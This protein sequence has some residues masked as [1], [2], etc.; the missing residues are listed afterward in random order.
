MKALLANIFGH[1][2]SPPWM[3]WCKAHPGKSIG[4]LLALLLVSAGLWTAWDWYQHLP[5]PQTVQSSIFAP[6][7]TNYEADK[8]EV[9]P[10][11]IRFS[12]SVAPLDNIGKPLNKGIKLSPEIAGQ[13]RWSSD[14]HLE[15][16]PD[17]DWPVDKSYSLTLD[18]ETLLASHILLDN[19]IFEFKTAP[20]SAQISD[21]RLYYEPN[22][23]N[24]QKV[25]ATVHFSHPVATQ[26]VKSALS[27]ML[28]PGLTY[29]QG[30]DYQLTFDD[31][32]LNAYIHTAPLATPLEPSTVK[33]ELSNRIKAAF[34]GNAAEEDSAEVSVPGRYQ[35]S[36]SAAQISFAKNDQEEPEPVLTMESSR[37]VADEALKGKVEAWLLPPKDPQGNTYWDTQNITDSVLR[38]AS[39][40]TLIQNPGPEGLNQLHSFKFQ[41]PV[42]RYLAVRVAKHV[43]GQGGY[44]SR[45]AA[46]SV[47]R[48]P[49]YPKALAFLGEGALLTLND[50]QRLGYL[51]RGVADVRI[52][53]AQLLPD[54]IH[55]L[56][57][58]DS[59][60]FKV[61]YFNNNLFDR[62]VTRT[63][64]IQKFVTNDPAKTSYGEV[65][66]KSYFADKRGIFVLK[67]TSAEDHNDRTFDSYPPE[68]HDLRFVVVT[69]MGILAKRSV[70]GS[71][72]IFVQS[73]S[74]GLP[75]ANAKVDVVGRNGLSVAEGFTDLDGH[76]H[77]P[78]LGQ[79]R[80]EKRPLFYRVE[81][82][83]DVSFLPIGDWRRELDMSR[84]D[85][86]GSNESED[87]NTLS[88]YLFTD[89]GLYRPGET[90]HVAS[91]VRSQ[92]WGASL[93]GLPVKMVVTDP[94]GIDV[95]DRTFNLDS[96]GFNS[97]D[98]S[99][100]ETAVAGEY[101]ASLSLIRDK[102]NLTR[103]GEVSFKV[104]D[105]E[106]DRI[107]VRVTLGATESGTSIGWLKPEE[108]S[109]K[110]QAEQ[111]FGG[112]AGDRRVTGEMVLSPT[113]I[114]FKE[115]PGYYFGVLGELKESFRETLAEAKTN[116]EGVAGLNLA[117]DRF[118][119]TTFKLHL[120]AK[121]YEAG[122]GRNVSAQD[123]A[124]VSNADFLLG[125]KADGDLGFISKDGE[126][127]LKLV[128][129]GQDLKPRVTQ[130]QSERI[131]RRWVSVLVK[132]RDGTYR[133]ESRRKDELLESKTLQLNKGQLDI[134]LDTSEP[135]DYQLRF[136]D[137][138]G[139][140]LNQIDYS[141]AGQGNASR[142]LERNAELQL[143]LDKDEY[144]PGDTI[145]IAIQAPYTGAGL[146]TIERDKVY[147]FE[148]FKA[149]SSRSVQSIQLPEGIEGNAY[150]NVQFLR[151]P[152]SDEIFMSPL[153][154]GV[155]PIKIDLGA[156]RQ[157][158]SLTLPEQM[159][160]GNDLKIALNLPTDSKVVVFGVDEGILQV[161]R[162][163]A[164]DPLGHFFAKKAL[165]V[166][167]SQI[168]D[169]LL[170]DL[171]VLMRNAAPGGDAEA[172]LAAN[173]NPFKRKRASPVVYWSGLQDLS[174]GEQQFN[175]SVPDTFN[176]KIHFFA[177]SVTD[178]NMGVA[179][180][181][182]NVKAPVV[183]TPNVPAF[184]APGD[185]A[186]I[187]LGLYNTEPTSTRVQVALS[188][189]GGLAPLAGAEQSF[190]ILPGQ[191]V[192]A[193][194]TLKAI[195]PLGEAKLHWALKGEQGDFKIGESISIRPLTT[196]RVQLQT[197][198]L[199]SS[200]KQ[201]SLER[202]LFEPFSRKEAGLQSSPLVWAQGLSAYLE[203]YPHACTEQLVSK[204]VPALVL[205]KPQENLSAFNQLMTQLRSR[206]NSEGAFG[207]WA[208][209]PV[210]EPMVTLYVVDMLL[211]A[212]GNGYA[213]PQDM[214]DRANGYLSELS[215]SPSSGL[216]E[217]RQRAYGAYLLAR[218]G[219]QVSGALADIRDRL[220]RYYPK[221]WQSDIASAWLA[222]SFTLM[223]QQTLAK[224]LWD[225][226]VWELM[227][228]TPKHLDLY[229][230]PLVHDAQLLTLVARHA[231]ERL[232]KLPEGLLER[233]GNW[234]SAQRYTSLSA[235][236]LV[237]ALAAY[238]QQA[239][240]G[241]L[242]LTA[243]VADKWVI[244]NLPK[245]ELPFTANKIKVQKT[246]D[247]DA[248]Y[249]S[250]E[251]GFD[252]QPVA[253]FSHGLE[254][255]RDYLDLKGQPLKG[256]KVGEEFLVRLRLRATS[257][258]QLEQVVVIDLLPGG[259][260][261]VYRDKEAVVD[262]NNVEVVVDDGEE[263]GE[264]EESGEGG[265]EGDGEEGEAFN[266]WQPPIGV[267]EQ[268]DWSPTWLNVRE[269]RVVLYGTASRDVGTF[270]YKARATNAGHFQVP[271][272]YA[273]GLYDPLQQ[274][275]GKGS[276]LI[277][278]AP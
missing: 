205:G 158:L 231:P 57:D 117:L 17:T 98:F 263:G 195:E 197:A 218:Q 4:S 88:A 32:H 19:Y 268:S 18:G 31:K 152:D 248:F 273:E 77:L 212:Q 45:D 93:N 66:L 219:V 204:S 187:T 276:E 198:V 105:F 221:D 138:E 58:E 147:A 209:N 101:T 224:P 192:T 64:I 34:G 1:W 59:G 210:V 252:K 118:G 20:F 102:H 139:H 27:V 194:F 272:P 261:P 164:P 275:L 160:P 7:L 104:R 69:D 253:A 216:S 87:P 108:V 113:D 234:L 142:A 229:L 236:T 167:S 199:D 81:K 243:Q 169:L 171:N 233:V 239:T 251:S 145:N 75:I 79:L 9:A 8:P 90:A 100:T 258:E 220:Q 50:D 267:G 55:Q 89:R 196:H 83:G 203:S 14:K 157:P 123:K 85:T 42:G 271:A 33:L 262:A 150:V 143:K 60:I 232:A 44:L 151:A 170:P 61:Q 208:A 155:K 163:K 166:N 6:S 132:Q 106:P 133:Y 191:E 176:G 223:Q 41:A 51:V 182:V 73:L 76:V 154:Y 109:A 265:E 259:V 63:E 37:P 47:V 180:A 211:D 71:L 97:L 128:A 62:L 95:L 148:W 131:A 244:Q 146:I 135:G 115:W 250:M 54:Q 137:A 70:D 206:Q 189:E 266:G 23:P 10:L 78:K 140:Q 29:S 25:V 141:V 126:R 39:K 215:S 13:W 222:A 238:D 172:L 227:Q 107:K 103:L 48:M 11:V 213:V 94:R 110:V 80:R 121:V 274:A 179:E 168:L 12:D 68:A 161:A 96:S 22:Q 84:F 15:F 56:V 256:L 28:S 235:G 46:F 178:S 188:L 242:T 214:L 184:M 190:D 119:Q 277:I 246:G 193:R 67:L 72:D 237:R 278:S 30:S 134:A 149:D 173:L 125:Y 122:S 130:L 177:V 153:S 86:G 129:V 162:Y 35:L 264:G 36:F 16:Q 228:K 2:Q 230:D 26:T 175:Y 240:S 111:L 270:T 201:L 207:G 74:L 225:A 124:L 120:L 217:L 112:P 186:E 21:A 91:L 5:Q 82:A 65:D 202:Q 144:Q 43:E 249:M 53:V 185:E 99:S 255:S 92:S 3:R 183:M 254:V 241:E 226:Q 38:K 200:E 247:A 127:H 260:E 52:E 181:S 174:A 49:E 114:S 116:E 257:L 156:R 269:D 40:V 245:A 24:I 136:I 165:T 159:K